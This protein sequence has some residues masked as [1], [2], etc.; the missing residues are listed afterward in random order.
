MAFVIQAFTNIEYL[1][2]ASLE[3]QIEV[4]LISSYA[5]TEEVRQWNIN[6]IIILSEGEVA[7]EHVQYPVV[8]KYQACN[9]VVKETLGYYVEQVKEFDKPYIRQKKEAVVLGIY[10]HV[11]RSYKTT[12]ALTLGQVLGEDR[13]TLYLNLEEYSGLESLFQT[14]FSRDLSDLLYFLKEDQEHL[15]YYLV[16]CVQTIGTLDYVPPLPM[17]S[18]LRELE[19]ERWEQLMIELSQRSAYEVI[20]LDLSDCL[21]DIYDKL[22]SCHRILMPIEQDC[23]AHA[24]GNQFLKNL[25][26]RGMQEI[27][28]RVIQLKIPYVDSLAKEEYVPLLFPHSSLGAYTKEIIDTELWEVLKGEKIHER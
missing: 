1:Y 21:G 15:D 13:K 17:Y 11:R 5:M 14:S 9:Q 20:I 3:Y 22:S 24:K 7:K 28:E 27:K 16:S 2:A 8:Y 19:G 23:L 26:L 12:F 10:S 25:E 18:D 4:L 6:N